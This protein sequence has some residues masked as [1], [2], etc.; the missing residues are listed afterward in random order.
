MHTYMYIHKCVD[1]WPIR[2]DIVGIESPTYQKMVFRLR[3]PVYIY[4][5]IYIPLY[6]F[7]YGHLPVWSGAVTH[8]RGTDCI[9]GV[10]PNLELVIHC[11]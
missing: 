9:S 5:Y 1:L 6:I 7:L 3:D 11:N 10:I 2:N 4:I 8:N